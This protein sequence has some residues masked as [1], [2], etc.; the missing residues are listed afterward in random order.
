MLNG[1]RLGSVFFMALRFGTQVING[2]IIVKQLGRSYCVNFK[3]L[4]K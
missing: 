2:I 3:G 4:L 1:A